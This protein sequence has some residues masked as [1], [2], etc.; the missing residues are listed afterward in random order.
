MPK[1]NL[2]N[3]ITTI[4]SN[5]SGLSPAQKQSQK[6]PNQTQFVSPKQGE[7][8]TN[9]ISIEGKRKSWEVFGSQLGTRWRR[10]KEPDAVGADEVLSGLQSADNLQLNYSIVRNGS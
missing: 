8:R 3:Y 2:T 9:P 7:G 6:N 10:S 1:M 4:Y 5:I